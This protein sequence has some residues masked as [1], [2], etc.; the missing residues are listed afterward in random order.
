VRLAAE[1]LL[2]PLGPLEL[3][4]ELWRPQG[5]AID[6]GLRLLSGAGRQ[7]VLRRF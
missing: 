1:E 7:R 5:L 4:G 6:G 3:E 2:L